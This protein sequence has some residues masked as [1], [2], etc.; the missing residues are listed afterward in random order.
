MSSP[1]PVEMSEADF[2]WA[3]QLMERRRERYAHYSPVFWRPARGIVDFHARFLRASG[4]RAG[5]T[6]LRTARGFIIS[7]PNQ[8]RCFVDDF[9]VEEDSLWAGEGKALLLAAWRRARGAEQHSLRV[10]TARRDEPKRAMLIELGLTANARWWVKELTAT[11]PARAPGPLDILDVPAQLVAAPPVYDPGGPVCL[12]G[13][14][15]ASR[16]AAAAESAAA[17]GAVLVIVQREGGDAP[18]PAAEPALEAAGYH[19]PSEL[20]QGRPAV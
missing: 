11:G 12:L 3:A 17:A 6:A 4:A 13:D 8:G 15:D 9:A 14:V 7:W 18:V 19:N 10:V 16:A 5:A 1:A 2:V 20:Y